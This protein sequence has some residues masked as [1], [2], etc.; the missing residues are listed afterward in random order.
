MVYCL[1]GEEQSNAAF[2]IFKTAGIIPVR[3]L[4]WQWLKTI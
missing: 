3:E 2:N 4:D 1:K